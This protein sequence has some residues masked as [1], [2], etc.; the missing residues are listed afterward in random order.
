[1]DLGL[2][3][4]VYVVG[5]GSRGL[6][7]AVARA[8]TEEGARVVLSG[9]NAASLASAV[10]ALNDHRATGV[11]A[12]SV[13]PASPER[14]VAAA[15]DRWGRL[16]GALVNS[17]GPPIGSALDIPDDTWRG[18]FES[19]FLGAV[20]NAR[21]ISANLSE[22][23]SLAFVLSTSVR[24]PIPGLDVSNGLRPGLAMLTK[25]LSVQLGGQGIRVNALLPGRIRTERTDL[26]DSGTAGSSSTAIPLGRIGEPAEFGRIAAFVLSPAASYLSGAMIPVDGAAT[27]AY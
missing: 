21:V 15:L 24:V 3:D 11:V 4:R 22:G 20:R 13:D 10:E 25:G 19:V 18:S 9:R 7:F 5:G 16:D 23:G 17:G 27:Q 8:L 26:V 6:G 12:D 14:L 1:M 2:A